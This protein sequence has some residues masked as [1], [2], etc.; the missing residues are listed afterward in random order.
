MCAIIAI[1]WSR[2]SN[3]EE[4]F[5]FRNKKYT[6]E[7][8]LLRIYNSHVLAAR[9]SNFILYSILKPDRHF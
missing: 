9:M 1:K 5:Y 3:R 8:T 4:N 6:K 7:S 2:R